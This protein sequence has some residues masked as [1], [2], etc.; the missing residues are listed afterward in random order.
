MSEQRSFAWSP[1]YRLNEEHREFIG[2]C[3]SLI[4]HVSQKEFCY[5]TNC[6]PSDVSHALKN[7]SGHHFR[8]RWAM[9]LQRVSP[10]MRL[11]SLFVGPGFKIE[12]LVNETDAQRAAKY[13]AFIRRNPIVERAAK[14][15]GVLL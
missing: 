5:A 4:D 15:E 3:G 7:R 1:N 12:R 11:A 6:K 13:E 2:E 8:S 9:W 10:T 14:E